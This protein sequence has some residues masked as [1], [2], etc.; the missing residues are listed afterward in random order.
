MVLIIHHM[1]IFASGKIDIFR[2]HESYPPEDE[3]T[4]IF[5]APEASIAN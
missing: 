2:T 1:V 3:R 5:P 4:F